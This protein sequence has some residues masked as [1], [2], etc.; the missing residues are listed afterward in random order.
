M[1]TQHIA[2]AAFVKVS[3]GSPSGNRVAQLIQRGGV[4]PGGIDEAQLE[5]LVD[6]GLIEAVD[7]EDADETEEEETFDEGVYK[8]V[9]V[10]D[11]KAD[12]VT[13]NEGREG[14]AVITP[15]EPGNRPQ[16][17]A[18]LLADDTK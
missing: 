17:I 1:S 11:L 10:K 7:V 4:I 18:A 6:R 3:I 9:S 14:D 13:R 15:A 5:R 2:S 8:G 16:I 12:L